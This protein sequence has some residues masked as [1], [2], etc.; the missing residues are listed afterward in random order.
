MDF[1]NQAGFWAFLTAMVGTM[2]W[3]A[4]VV[5]IYNQK[6]LMV[7]A[8][9]DSSI[10]KLKSD[11]IDKAIASLKLTLGNI[12]PM[13]KLHEI[14]MGSLDASLKNIALYESNLKS[15]TD[16]LQISYK[17]FNTIVPKITASG[18]LLMDRMVKLETEIIE[19][20]NGDIFVRTKK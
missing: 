1:Y 11:N 8:K 2:R 6:N 17:N 9:F 10:E 18:Q 3:L 13:V 20:K 4:R 19:F 12:E 15:M 7:K 5:Y 14:K 16:D